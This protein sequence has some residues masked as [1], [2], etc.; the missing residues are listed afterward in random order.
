[1][2]ACHGIWLLRLLDDLGIK[3]TDP[4]LYHEDNQSAIRVME[5]EKESNRLKHVDVKF[6]F[7]RDLVQRGIIELR[8]VPINN[9]VADI[10]TKG[11][12]AKPYLQHRMVLGMQFSEN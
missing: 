2:T 8:Y 5:E 9:Q 7:V 3:V 1:M 12:P 10:M 4:V 11:L 6:R